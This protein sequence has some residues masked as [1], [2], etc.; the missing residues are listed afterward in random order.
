MLPI[1]SSA[2]GEGTPM[3]RRRG[4]LFVR[5]ASQLVISQGIRDE[6]DKR[7]TKLT[8]SVPRI[9]STAFA[10]Q[11]SEIARL[12]LKKEK[13]CCSDFP[14]VCVVSQSMRR[15]PAQAINGS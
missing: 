13:Q 12:T 4:V 2:Q 6:S 3:P 1:T 15:I 5:L 9:K 7:T 8:C 11:I 14:A 10:T